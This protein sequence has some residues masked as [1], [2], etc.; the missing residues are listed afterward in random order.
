MWATRVAKLGY[1]WKVGNGEKV[2][3]WEDNWVGPA[4]LAIQF[5]D[6]Y[7]LINEQN[8]TIF[9]LWDGE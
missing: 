4:S 8:K 6:I 1:M 9:E 5:W 7:S 2:R 3:F